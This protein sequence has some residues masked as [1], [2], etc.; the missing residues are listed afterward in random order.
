MMLIGEVLFEGLLEST[1]LLGN[2]NDW[3]PAAAGEGVL[4]QIAEDLIK[5]VC[6][7]PRYTRSTKTRQ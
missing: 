4:V 5:G 1:F 3:L 7:L 2:E 6:M